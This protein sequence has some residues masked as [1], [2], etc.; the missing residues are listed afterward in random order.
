MRTSFYICLVVLIIFS[1]LTCTAN[2]DYS[3]SEKNKSD[4]TKTDGE[5]I[6]TWE[7]ETKGQLYTY[8]HNSYGDFIGVESCGY[9]DGYGNFYI[10]VSRNFNHVNS[11]IKMG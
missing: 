10:I 7:K 8:N 4:K 9:A 6:S 3:F 5:V 11:P 1:I 2:S